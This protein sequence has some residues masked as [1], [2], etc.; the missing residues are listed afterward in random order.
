MKFGISGKN[1]WKLRIRTCTLNDEAISDVFWAG[2]GDSKVNFFE[3]L[4]A[5][6]DL[7]YDIESIH[8]PPKVR[9]SPY[10]KTLR[11]YL[12]NRCWLNV[13]QMLKNIFSSSA[14]HFQYL[15]RLHISENHE[16]TAWRSFV[17]S[18]PLGDTRPYPKYYSECTTSKLSNAV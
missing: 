7:V 12:V 2:P 9:K 16:I 8:W 10:L 5:P 4:R 18:I 14:E 6:W 11:P 17:N 3:I 1:V 13:A 15:K